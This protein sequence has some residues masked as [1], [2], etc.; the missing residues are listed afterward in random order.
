MERKFDVVV[1]GSGPGGYKTAKLLLE[2]GLK[3]CL[4]EKAVFGGT[5]LNAGCIPKDFIYNLC[6]ATRKVKEFS[7]NVRMSWTEVLKVIKERI[8]RLR[9]AAETS[10]RS[11]GLEVVYGEAELIEEKVVKVNGERLIGNYIVLACGSKQKEEGISPEDILT[12]R[13]TPTGKVLIKGEGPSACELAFILKTFNLEVGILIKDRLLSSLYQV[14]ESF[15]DKL[16][17]ALEEMGVEIFEEETEADTLIVATG[18]IPNLCPERFPLVQK[19]AEGFVLVDEHLETSIPGVYAVGDI[20]P[21]MGAGYAFEKARV[22]VQNILY[23]NSTRFEPERVPVVIC[24][25]YE[26]GFVGSQEKVFRTEHKA[27]T[28]NPKNFINH[29]NGILRIGYDKEGNPVFLCALGHGVPEVL[30][31]FSGI[32]GGSFSHPSYGEIVE[33]LFQNRYRK[34][35][36][37]HK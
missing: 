24:S 16:G 37:A 3:V 9:E 28:L 30:N 26:V 31:T 7:S 20:V 14:P 33:E 27:M 21:P 10:L 12:G 36:T 2:K 25:A 23:G 29:R 11:K 15:S 35:E 13:C 5:C 1:V 8:T 22:V 17:T 4:V 19:D 32:V 18:R 6:I 34:G